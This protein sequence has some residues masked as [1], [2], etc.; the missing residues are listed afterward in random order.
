MPRS[1]RDDDL[2]PADRIDS[3]FYALAQ[4]SYLIALHPRLESLSDDEKLDLAT[5][6][7][8]ATEYQAAHIL[9]T[10]AAAHAELGE[11]EKAE[12]QFDV[13]PFP[14]A[15]GQRRALLPRQSASFL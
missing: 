1:E 5:K 14:A 12:A 10:L 4:E 15:H 6:A 7:C 13:G 9:S 3:L 11:F 8:E 2:A